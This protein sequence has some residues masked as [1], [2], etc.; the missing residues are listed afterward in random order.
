[1]MQACWSICLVTG[2]FTDHNVDAMISRHASDRC[3]NR[4]E[5]EPMAQR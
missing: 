4:H 5:D 3:R 2:F 1:M